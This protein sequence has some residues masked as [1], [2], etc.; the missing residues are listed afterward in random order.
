MKLKKKEGQSVD[1]SLFLRR[2][3][4]I[5]MEGVTETKYGAETKGKTIQSRLNL[6]V[7]PIYNR[8]TLTLLWMPGSACWTHGSSHI[9]S[10]E[11]PCLASMR[12]EALGP[13]K[14]QCPSVGECQGREVGVDGWVGE[15]PHRSR[16]GDREFL[17]GKLGKELT[18]E[19]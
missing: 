18:L 15:H 5:H 3:N 13:V 6:G 8:Q 11:W 1:T 16:G 14:A 9:Y 17:E 7:H 10:K 19:M 2:G 4:K 12:G